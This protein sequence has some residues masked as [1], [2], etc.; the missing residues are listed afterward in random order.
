MQA[1]ASGRFTFSEFFVYNIDLTDSRLNKY[2]DM[3]RNVA[4][5]PVVV[6]L[7]IFEETTAA[8]QSPTIKLR[9]FPAGSEILDLT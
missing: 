6:L 1:M 7:I 2:F 4:I 3:E 5:K 8:K 9:I